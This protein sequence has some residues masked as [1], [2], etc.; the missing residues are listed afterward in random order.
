M[1]NMT[2]IY[3]EFLVQQ[4]IRQRCSIIRQEEGTKL[5]LIITI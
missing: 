5:Q 3:N 2:R 1:E 4:K